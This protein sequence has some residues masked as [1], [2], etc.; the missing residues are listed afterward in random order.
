ML[1]F[2]VSNYFHQ[3]LCV[4]FGITPAAFPANLSASSV[5]PTRL[6]GNLSGHNT[7][8][9]N[10]AHPLTDLYLGCVFGEFQPNLGVHVDLYQGCQFYLTG[11]SS[12]Q[13]SYDGLTLCS[14]GKRNAV[15][16]LNWLLLHPKAGMVPVRL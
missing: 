2:K 10:G 16:K 7:R 14:L 11:C 1:V 13:V 8:V 12:I 9:Q 6:L 15:G 5:Q 3:S 4:A